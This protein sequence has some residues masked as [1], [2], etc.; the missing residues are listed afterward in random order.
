MKEKVIY[1]WG[2]APPLAPSTLR[3]NPLGWVGASAVGGAVAALL[4]LAI[5][6]R[7][8]PGLPVPSGTLAE[9]MASWLE[10]AAHA[11]WKSS[12]SQ[13]SQAYRKLWRE[14]AHPEQIGLIWRG[15]CAVWAACMPSIFLAKPF[16]TPRDGLIHLRGSFRHEGVEGV[17]KLVAAL[18]ARL[19]RRPDH[20]IAPGVAYPSDMWTR[21]VLVVGGVGS[22]KSTAIKP[23]IEKIVEANEQMLLFDPKSEFTV[24]FKEPALL[25]PWD[26]RSLSWD[27]AKD[28]RNQLDMRRF[29]STMIRESQ[30]PMWSNA[31]RQL[32][33]G[34]M[35]YL[36]SNRGND[37]GWMELR[38]LVALPQTNLLLI[39]KEWH[40]EAVRAVEK[41]SVTTAGILI[42]LSSFCA[43]IFDLA[44]AWGMAP[45]DRRVSFVEW[46]QGRSRHRQ[47]ILQGHGAYADLTK[48]YVEGIVGIVSAMVNSVEMEDDP[49]R[50]I[51]FIAD[52]F[53]Q[54]GKIPVRPLFE[55]GRSRGVRCVVA[56]QDLA[57]VEELYGAPMV[58]AL[59]GM[60]GTLLIGQ[61]M[62]GETAEQICKA[63]GAREVERAN[64]S[65]SYGGAGSGPNRST[66]LSF[67]RDEVP[68]YKPS[69]LSSRLGLT[70]DGTG[71][72]MILFTGGHAYEL[73][74]P[75]YQI[76]RERMGHVPAPWTLGFVV[77]PKAGGAP[78]VHVGSHG[79]SRADPVLMSEKA[80]PLLVSEKTDSVL[81][82]AKA[83]EISTSEVAG[84]AE[85]VKDMEQETAPSDGQHAAV[86]PGI[87]RAE[88]K[89]DAPLYR[90]DEHGE[91][92]HDPSSRHRQEVRASHVQDASEKPVLAEFVLA[93]EATEHFAHMTG[94]EA[95]SAAMMAAGVIDQDSDSRS[96]PREEVVPMLA[97]GAT[98]KDVDS[99]DRK[100]RRPEPK[101]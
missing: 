32:L 45:P 40:P 6:W 5:V 27:I 58:K 79:E 71:V 97:N 81:M 72:N 20:E 18:A 53:A 7:P 28:M 19:K 70:P 21:H 55:V 85:D 99:S 35:I 26:K 87:G 3:V 65:S 92:A 36:K 51:W 76:R 54:M 50:K 49:A 43:T 100:Q 91:R 30:D 52:E 68:L 69:E 10:L 64:L 63:F 67:N 90:M 77:R 78:F 48:S 17:T 82:S 75:H 42:N 96:G 22:G 88:P 29:A 57:Q 44:E 14:T 89:T 4:A 62:Q 60:C 38:D 93:P 56:C 59:V 8:F 9:H 37:W 94:L 12:F 39:M 95:L 73:Y 11:L 46:T 2:Q 15:A 23:L 83:A 74:W 13:E 98:A 34:L 84:E 25:A 24:G 47:I 80:D 66:T 61:T 1:D 41:A 16:L 101:P 86:L 33:V 31:S